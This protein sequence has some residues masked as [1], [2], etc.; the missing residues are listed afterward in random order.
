LATYDFSTLGSKNILPNHENVFVDFCR[1]YEFPFLQQLLNSRFTKLICDSVMNHNVDIIHDHGLW[2]PSNRAS[3]FVAKKKKLPLIVN[4]RGMLSPWAMS[5]KKYKKALCWYAYQKRNLA[6]AT[7]FCATSQ[8][9]VDDIRNLGFK[10]P[11]ACIPNGVAI[12]VIEPVAN[13]DRSYRTLLFLGRIHPVK[14]LVNLIHAWSRLRPVGWKICIAGPDEGGYRRHLESLVSQLNLN[15]DIYFVGSVDGVEK[16]CLL[17]NA[18]LFVLPTHTENFGIVVAEALAYG[19]PVITT[20]GAPWESLVVNGSGW[21]IDIGVDPL[22]DALQEAISLSDN[23][24]AEMGQ[25]GRK[26]VTENFS[27]S[28]IASDMNDFYYWILKGGT[29]PDSVRL[30]HAPR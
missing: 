18:D 26:F 4:P 15:D 9:E 12:P 6:N 16:D 22:A 23:Q 29:L 5:Y 17:K 3:A 21:W 14:G 13:F 10:Q 20:K 2:L 27:W 8:Q 30:I 24:R 11:I 19:V 1:P 25:L 7:A 28:K